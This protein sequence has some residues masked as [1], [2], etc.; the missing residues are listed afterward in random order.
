VCAVA[1]DWETREARFEAHPVRGAAGALAWG[2]VL[3]VIAVILVGALS[4][5]LWAFGVFSSDIKGQGDAQ[6]IKNAGPNRVKAQELFE[7]RYQDILAAD[8]TVV[9]S[10]LAIAQDPTNPQLKT[11][12]IGQEQYC[13]ALVGKYNADT[14]KFSM[15]DFRSTDL[16][17]QI[18][19]ND[20][21]TDCKG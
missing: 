17:F 7:T 10:S 15:E 8:R 13:V 18:D 21:A 1:R 4:I 3:A 9:I 14:R 11:Q 12:L 19:N 16:P 2:W 20:T 5:A 6:K